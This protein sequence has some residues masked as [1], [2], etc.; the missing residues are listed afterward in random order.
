MTMTAPIEPARIR[1]VVLV[2]PRDAGKTT[3]VEQLALAT[4]ALTRSG[5]VEEGTTLSETEDALSLVSVEWQGVRIN[6]LDTPGEADV[7]SE[8]R[9]GLRAADA[10]LFVVSAD[11]GVDAA[12]AMLWDECAAVSMPRAIVVTKAEAGD[13]AAEAV[14][15][16]DA[17]AV[18][19][20][21]GN[22]F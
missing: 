15:I 6:L 22:A 12:T 8:V 14:V 18:A 4:G 5:S 21:E 13:R 20:A 7:E 1:N 2:G 11:E 16:A 3:L 9:A 10:A 17:E 19:E